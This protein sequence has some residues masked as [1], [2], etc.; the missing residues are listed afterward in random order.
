MKEYMSSCICYTVYQRE[1]FS[2]HERLQTRKRAVNRG[3]HGMQAQ[4]HG[5]LVC[6]QARQF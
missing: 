1:G 5:K 6:R 4:S 2:S 3:V